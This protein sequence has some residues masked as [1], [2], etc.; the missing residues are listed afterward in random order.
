M[1]RESRWA[2]VWRLPRTD[3]I[4]LPR[5]GGDASKCCYLLC[6]S[7][8]M[9]PR[10]G[11]EEFL[12]GGCVIG[13][14]AGFK[15]GENIKADPFVRQCQGFQPADELGD[16]FESVGARSMRWFSDGPRHKPSFVGPLAT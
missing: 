1:L 2:P 10:N 13:L 11:G 4:H 14:V 12:V 16:C 3:T 7:R 15:G 5:P 6:H 8:G 9:Q